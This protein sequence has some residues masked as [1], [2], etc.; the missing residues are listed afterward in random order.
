MPAPETLA[1]SAW[2]LRDEGWRAVAKVLLVAGLVTLF[3][4]VFGELGWLAAVLLPISLAKWFLPTWY[5]LGPDGV[6]VRFVGVSTRA[7]W[8]RYRR[9][10]AHSVGVHLSTFETPSPLDPFRGLFLR[11]RGNREAVV[12][13]L[14]Q[15]GLKRGEKKKPVAKAG[16]PAGPPPAGPAPSG[17]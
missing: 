9:F 2:P 11:F 1:W 14:E 12:A 4:L 8:A 5:Q 17:S 15:A 7:P 3:F 13:R 10:Y 6:V 16:E